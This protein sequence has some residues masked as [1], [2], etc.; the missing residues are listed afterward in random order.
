MNTRVIQH[1]FVLPGLMFAILLSGCLSAPEPAAEEVQAAS[2]D[3]QEVPEGPQ[4]ATARVT[5]QISE[6]GRATVT[7]HKDLQFSVDAA[8]SAEGLQEIDTLLA[9]QATCGVFV[10]EKAAKELDVPLSGAT[11][12]SVFD[13]DRQKVHVYLDLPGA[14]S[15]QILE[16]ANNFRQRCPIYTTLAEAESIEFTPGEQFETVADDAAMVTAT[17]FRFGATQ[18]AHRSG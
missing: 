5:A 16:L 8:P 15:D 7:G 4:L 6:P 17:L 10:A 14:N 9:A 12:T 13:E 18:P 1:L 2:E 3:S 11:A